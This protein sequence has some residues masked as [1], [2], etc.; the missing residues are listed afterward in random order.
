MNEKPLS[1]WMGIVLLML[2]ATTFGSNHI[3]ARIAFD[4]GASVTTAVTV[5]SVFTALFVFLLM[6]IQGVSFELPSLTRRR[7]MLIGV[8]LAV[9]SFCLYSSVARLPVALALLSFNTFPILLALLSWG[10]GGERPS[11]IAVL[12]MPLALIGLSL[13]LDVYGKGGDV[14]GRWEEIGVG[15]SWGVSAG[16]FF[17]LVLLLTARWLNDVDGRLRTFMTMSVAAII[18]LIGGWLSSGFDLPNAQAGWLGL[19]LLS[20]FYASA[21]TG[22]FM[23][24]PRIGAVNNA[25]VLN[26]EPIALLGLAWLILGQAVSALQIVG[27]FIVVGAISLLSMA[28]R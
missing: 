23:V 12:A 24:L 10:T 11:R 17:A 14:V 8:L 15:V 6:K 25:V 3:A 21:F 27:A 5:R 2:I 1:R 19:F 18:M 4:H 7:A 22:L 16:F 9:Q 20:L 13:A 26:F 28:K